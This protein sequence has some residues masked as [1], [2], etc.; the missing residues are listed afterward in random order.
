[1]ACIDPHQTGFAG[2]G[3]DSLQLIKCRPSRAPGKG[4]CGGAKFL[5]PPCSS[6]H[7]VFASPPSAFLFEK[8]FHRSKGWMKHIFGTY[9]GFEVPHLGFLISV[10][11]P[12]TDIK[13]PKWVGWDPQKSHLWRVHSFHWY[14]WYAIQFFLYRL[15]AGYRNCRRFWLWLRPH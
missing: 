1:M 11:S 12:S 3:S 8:W 5:A 9:F 10:G 14:H 4:V 7:P 15:C 6:Q 2:K 13:N